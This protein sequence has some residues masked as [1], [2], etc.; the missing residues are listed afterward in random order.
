MANYYT[1]FEEGNNYL[2]NPNLPR[3]PLQL[4]ISNSG[5]FPDVYRCGNLS[6]Q[7]DNDVKIFMLGFGSLQNGDS[8]IV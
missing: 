2:V 8:G 3:F 7:E 5:N 6:N 1:T 4:E